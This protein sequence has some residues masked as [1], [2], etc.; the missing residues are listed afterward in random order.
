MKIIPTK[1]RAFI[2]FIITCRILI[3][4]SVTLSGYIT[5]RDTEK[6]LPGVNIMIKGTDFGTVADEKGTFSIIYAGEFPVVLEFSHVGYEVLEKTITDKKERNDLIITLVPRVLP[7]AEVTIVG[8][9]SRGS[10]DVSSSIEVSR[11]KTVEQRGIRDLGE[12]L[13]EMESVQV[14]TSERGRQTLSIRGSNPDEI[15]VYLDG[16]KINH[17]ATGVANLGFVDLSGLE[18]VEVIKGGG[19]VMFGGGNFGGVVLL[20]SRRPEKTSFRI[21][22]TSGITTGKDQDRSIATD[23]KWGPVG[24]GAQISGKSR[25]FDGRTLFDTQYRNFS[26]EVSTLRHDLILRH[27]DLGNAIEFPSGGVITA[28]RFLVDR[29]EWNYRRSPRNGWSLEGGRKQWNWE[30][31]FFSN[32]Q[33]MLKEKSQS[34][35]INKAFGF[36]ELE[37]NIQ[38]EQEDQHFSGN[39]AFLDNYSDK[40]LRDTT[41]LNQREAAL[42]ATIRYQARNPVPG[43]SL[44]KLEGGLRQGKTVYDEIQRLTQYED[45]DVSGLDTLSIRQSWNLQT[46]RIGVAAETN[47]WNQHWAIF[48]N[49]G[50]NTRLPNLSDRLLWGVG[51]KT[52]QDEYDRLIRIIPVTQYQAQKLQDQIQKVASI[53]TSMENGFLPENVSLVEVSVLWNREWTNTMPVDKLELGASVFRNFYNNKVAYRTVQD[54]LSIPYNTLTAKLHGWEVSGRVSLLESLVRVNTSYTRIYPSSASVFPGKPSAQ[55]QVTV[56]IGRSWFRTNLSYI[57]QGPQHY[58]EGGVSLTEL[59]S[60]SNMNATVTLTKQI[61]FLDVSLNY[62]VRNIFSTATATLASEQ[63]TSGDIFNYYDRHRRLISITIGYHDTQ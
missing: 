9:R 48:F 32:L 2:L 3:A 44:I 19:T 28:D 26:G 30:D 38:W 22:S 36:R 46:F 49:A 61:Y 17:V 13:Q 60:Q 63:Y 11:L 47:W 56:N 41:R 25:L 52:M 51:Q 16:V 50:E 10:Q 37:G 39:Q 57:W 53:L 7:G 42:A 58:L 14:A 4:Q 15:A 55:T 35:V 29:V 18:A 59:E 27:I 34:Y 33:R 20:R 54:D 8:S 6:Y 21:K 45:G 1:F 5:D 43:I 24:I 40:V 23:L 12:V 31:H 62:T